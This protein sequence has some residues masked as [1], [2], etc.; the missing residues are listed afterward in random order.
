[1]GLISRE[2][3]A[4]TIKL[5]YSSPVRIRDI[6]LGKYLGVLVFVF[7]LM[8]LLSMILL[9]LSFS[10]INPEYFLLFTA[11]VGIFLVVSTYAA[12]GLFVSSL[13]AYQIVAALITFAILILFK[14]VKGYWQDVDVIRYISY[15]LD[16][17]GKSTD[18][19]LGWINLRDVTY[20][21]IIISVFLCFTIIKLKSAT[22]SKHAWRKSLRYIT[23]III[24]L[25]VGYI[26]DRPSINMY[27]DA[28]RN[29]IYTIAKPTQQTLAKLNDGKLEITAYVN[30]LSDGFGQFA[31]DR[32][33]YVEKA[34]LSHTSVLSRIWRLISSFIIMLTALITD[35]HQP[36]KIDEGDCPAICW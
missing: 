5:L 23:V 27:F 2:K 14:Q 6:V 22:E 3:N 9:S 36:G 25:I 24:A 28:T 1:M 12:I 32:L 7:F 16:I 17:S 13:T 33:L 8:L 15:Y 30:L 4:E 29:D 31:P 21:L 18:I 34:C 11:V 26:T 35:G 10:I 20:F 19:I